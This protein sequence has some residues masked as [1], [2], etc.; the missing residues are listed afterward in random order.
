MRTV[1][2]NICSS[3]LSVSLQRINLYSLVL[4]ILK[5]KQASE[6]TAEGEFAYERTLN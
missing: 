1:I 6:K 3:N 5:F 4:A 2:G